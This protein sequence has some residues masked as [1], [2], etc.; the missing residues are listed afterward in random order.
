MTGGG[1]LWFT[2]YAASVEIIFL[3]TFQMFTDFIA[4]LDMTPRR[5]KLLKLR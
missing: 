3:Y 2:H 4:I 1:V 5:E